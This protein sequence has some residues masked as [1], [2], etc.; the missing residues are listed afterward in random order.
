MVLKLSEQAWTKLIGIGI[1]IL[2]AYVVY[3]SVQEHAP[4]NPYKKDL[5]E[6]RSS[7]NQKLYAVQPMGD[8][9]QAADYLARVD[10]NMSELINTLT[11]EYFSL[12]SRANEGEI[13]RED[14]YLKAM[15]QLSSANYNEIIESKEF[16]DYGH[17]SE[18]GAST[19]N[20]GE[21]ILLCIREPGYD[22]KFIDPNL[23]NFV[24]I[25]ELTHTITRSSLHDDEFWDT[26]A[27]LLFK[28][29]E[30][31]IYEYVDY[32]ANPVEY[33]GSDVLFNPMSRL[34]N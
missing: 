31:G 12:V 10:N 2:L 4:E 29:Q 33:C 1:F 34:G 11:L 13:S 7:T 8:S 3:S 5:I 26:M 18:S 32:A 22:D 15:Q 16:I 27:A 17:G 19:I 24:A 14:A 30:Y 6:V 20:Y 28:A 21:L 9:Q 25:H 23:L